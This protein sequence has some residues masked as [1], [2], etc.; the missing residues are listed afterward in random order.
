[1]STKPNP[2]SAF[3][4]WLSGLCLVGFVV[5]WYLLLDAP[6]TMRWAHNQYELH[7]ETAIGLSSLIWVPAFAVIAALR[8]ALTYARRSKSTVA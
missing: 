6:I 7:E 5:T 1:M 3:Y 8:A 2:I 4:W